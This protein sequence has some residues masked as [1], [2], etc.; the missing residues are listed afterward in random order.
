VTDVPLRSTSRRLGKAIS[1]RIASSSTRAQ[2]CTFSFS[3]LGSP[4]IFSTQRSETSVALTVANLDPS[5][6]TPIEVQPKRNFGW[7]PALSRVPVCDIVCNCLESLGQS[8]FCDDVRTITDLVIG[9]GHQKFRLLG[10]ICY[11]RWPKYP[12]DN[13][14]ARALA[15]T[16]PYA[17]LSV[18]ATKKILVVAFGGRDVF[19][20]TVYKKD[21]ISNSGPLT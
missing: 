12:Y 5:I 1:E 9:N 18:Q 8:N 14:A 13:Q 2:P 16:D 3:S 11:R 19:V 15:R 6:P 4:F 17:K 7:R 20:P 21:K 10:L